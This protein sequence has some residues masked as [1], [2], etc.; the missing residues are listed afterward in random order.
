MAKEITNSRPAA[1]TVLDEAH[2]SLAIHVFP[3]TFSCSKYFAS[4]FKGS[5]PVKATKTVALNV[6]IS[7][8]IRSSSSGLIVC[9]PNTSL[10]NTRTCAW[11]E[12]VTMVPTASFWSKCKAL[13]DFGITLCVRH[14]LHK[15]Y[16]KWLICHLMRSVICGEL[17][18]ELAR[19]L[20]QV[21]S[22]QFAF[23]V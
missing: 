16:F 11:D 14:W 5:A 2:A 6:L 23:S 22:L 17:H 20:S 12:G 3:V 4:C 10:Q 7:L 9:K 13:V 21:K 18:A 19:I 8:A 15:R 1:W